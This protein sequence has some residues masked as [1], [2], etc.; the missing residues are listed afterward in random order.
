M[1][2]VTSDAATAS[3]Y[4]AVQVKKNDDDDSQK[5]AQM[6]VIAIVVP[7]VIIA[8]VIV[9]VI[10]FMRSM[11]NSEEHFDINTNNRRA[12][13][14][15]RAEPV[16]NPIRDGRNNTNNQNQSSVAQQEV[17]MAQATQLGTVS[18]SRISEG[19]LRA[20]YTDNDSF[21]DSITEI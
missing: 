15:V 7:L 8:V 21:N 20:T 17:P 18:S 3:G 5:K 9:L 14:A 13:T 1:L 19:P 4:E 16:A 2:A 10:Y 11:K 12:P 6:T